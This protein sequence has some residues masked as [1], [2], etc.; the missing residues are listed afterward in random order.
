MIG[1]RLQARAGNFS[2]LHHA[3]TDFGAHPASSPMRTGRGRGLS[4]GIKRLE[5]EGDHSSSFF[6]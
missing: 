5:R 6:L 2:V 4:L 3:Q 1:V